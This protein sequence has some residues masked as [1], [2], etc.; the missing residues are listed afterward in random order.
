MPDSWVLT[1]DAVRECIERLRQYPVHEYFPAYLHLR[2]RAAEEGTTQ[3]IRPH[4]D[5][6]SLFLQVRNAPP[7]K[8]HFRPFTPRPGASDREWLNENLAGSYAPGSLRGNQPP[9]RV[10]EGGAQR[11]SFDL[12]EKHWE[13]AREHLLGGEQLPLIPL[14]AFMLRDFAFERDG[15]P[16]DADLEAAFAQAFGYTDETGEEEM[17]HLYDRSPMVSSG[18]FEPFEG[19]TT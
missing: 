9:L 10:V 11:Y 17:D 3:N 6:L 13:L 1:V 12:R 5:E 15:E 19:E 18:W 8:P 4:W 14:A 2:Q 16:G 7:K